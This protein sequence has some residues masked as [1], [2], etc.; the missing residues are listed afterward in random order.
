MLGRFRDFHM[1][2]MDMYSQWTQLL[3]PCACTP[4]ELVLIGQSERSVDVSFTFGHA[5]D[6]SQ[7]KEFKVLFVIQIS[8]I[9][10]SE[11]TLRFFSSNLLFF[12][13]FKL[14]RN[15]AHGVTLL[16]FMLSKKVSG[17]LLYFTEFYCCTSV[18]L[19]KSDF[20]WDHVCQHLVLVPVFPFKQLQQWLRLKMLVRGRRVKNLVQKLIDILD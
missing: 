15:I 2:F 9:C 5:L 1:R 3:Q 20:C 6:A 7:P 8:Q 13:A 14:C 12:Y 18:E 11:V 16:I 19:G 17:F 10:R 4:W